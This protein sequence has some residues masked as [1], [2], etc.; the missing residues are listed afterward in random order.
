MA[1]TNKLFPGYDQDHYPKL[2]KVVPAVYH[3]YLTTEELENLYTEEEILNL[4]NKA[5]FVSNP[6]AFAATGFNGAICKYVDKC[7]SG[8]LL[9]PA[10][11]SSGTVTA[12]QV[13]KSMRVK[14]IG[15]APAWVRLFI[16]IPTI[17]DDIDVPVDEK[18]CLLHFEADAEKGLAE[19]QWNFGKDLDREA[20]EYVGESGWNTYTTT[21]DGIA[22]NVYVVT[23][24][25]ALE[26]GQMSSEAIFQV[27]LDAEAEV[28]DIVTANKA[29]GTDEWQIYAAAEAVTVTPEEEEEEEEE[30]LLDGNEQQ[31]E[32]GEDDPEPEPETAFSAFAAIYEEVGEGKHN[33]FA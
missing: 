14:N 4:F 5:Y 32:E 33:P 29:F 16:A 25:T 30:E 20:G 11:I 15:T 8:Q 27:Y 7:S 26:P 21:I 24:E 12:G 13:I 31:Q 10:T 9:V 23:L 28:D 2:V 3:R 6:G 19:G 18:D 22:Y 1:N 17:L